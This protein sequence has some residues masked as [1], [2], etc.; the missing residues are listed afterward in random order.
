MKGEE[1]TQRDVKRCDGGRTRH[2]TWSSVGLADE[3]GSDE[4]I[5]AGDG[6]MTEFGQLMNVRNSVFSWQTQVTLRGVRRIHTL[7]S[8][9]ATLRLPPTESLCFLHVVQA[10][11][12][13]QNSITLGEG[14]GTLWQL[15]TVLKLNLSSLIDFCYRR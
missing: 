2:Y 10:K 15:P 4:P 6:G 3:T 9:K 7:D 13:A 14:S 11:S 5:Y 8:W 1:E 12:S